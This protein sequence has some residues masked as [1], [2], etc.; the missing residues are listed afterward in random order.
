MF[1]I[2]DSEES[3]GRRRSWR[4]NQHRESCP[5]PHGQLESRFHLSN[6]QLCSRFNS[7]CKIYALNTSMQGKTRS[8]FWKRPQNDF[9]ARKQQW[10]QFLRAFSNRSRRARCPKAFTTLKLPLC[11]STGTAR[12]TRR[13]TI[14]NW[15]IPTTTCSWCTT[16]S[17]TTLFSICK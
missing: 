12:T 15:R 11:T 17:R 10:S 13:T 4:S 7:K 3:G 9:P 6:I 2:G 8:A 1:F 14:T 5:S 16:T